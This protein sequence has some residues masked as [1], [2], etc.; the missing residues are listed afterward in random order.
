MTV[1][2]GYVLYVADTETTG[3]DPQKH[4]IIEL[5][6]IRLWLDGSRAEEQKTWLIRA[7]LP[8]NIEEEALKMN[9]H[10]REDIL[11]L[12]KHGKENYIHPSKVLSEIE[13]WMA[14]D[15]VTV[16]DRVMSGHNAPFDDAM[17][18]AM[19]KRH[20]A[21]DTYPFQLGVNKLLLDTKQLAIF[22]D[23]I[24]GRRRKFYNLGSIIKDYGIKKEKTHRAESD[25]RMTKDL[26]LKQIAP[27][28]E[29]VLE[30]F[31]NTYKDD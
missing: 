25:T 16:N 5:S 2:E 24:C 6:T 14:E 23:V 30:A 12:T 9:G 20:G 8:E 1:N 4:E 10:K 15:D 7:T 3:T 26:L 21:I 29:V 22:I 17:M 28:K 18:E 27:F 19:W 11:G 13:N 31:K